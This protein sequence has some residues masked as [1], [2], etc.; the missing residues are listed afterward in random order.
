MA[1]NERLETDPTQ[2]PLGGRTV[3]QLSFNANWF[4]YSWLDAWTLTVIITGCL[5]PAFSHGSRSNWRKSSNQDGFYKGN[6]LRYQFSFHY[7]VGHV[8]IFFFFWLI[9]LK[10]KG[11]VGSVTRCTERGRSYFW[12]NW[13]RAWTRSSTCWGKKHNSRA[14]TWLLYSIWVKFFVGW[15]NCIA[16]PDL[17]KEKW[18]L[19]VHEQRTIAL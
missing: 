10:F 9:L 12:S 2:S 7:L 6:F 5:W 3:W 19:L 14:G 13:E 17:E 16:N 4:I 8:M 1:V 18:L 15:M 11:A